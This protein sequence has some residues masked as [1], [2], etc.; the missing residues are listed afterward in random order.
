MKNKIMIG[1]VLCLVVILAG[2]SRLIE[3][4]QDY[5]GH[6]TDWWFPKSESRPRGCGVWACG[7]THNNPEIKE[8]IC[9]C[10]K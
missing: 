2:C 3:T 1:M 9:I 7:Y 5:E 6:G 4:G 8:Q 10:L